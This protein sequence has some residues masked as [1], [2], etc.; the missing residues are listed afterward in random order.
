MTQ[1][2]ETIKEKTDLF[3]YMRRKKFTQQLLCIS[4]I[5]KKFK[6]SFYKNSYKSLRKRLTSHVHSYLQYEKGK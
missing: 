1:G 5:K 6:K 3:D 4:K 2:F